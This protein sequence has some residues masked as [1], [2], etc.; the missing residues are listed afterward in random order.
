MKNFLPHSTVEHR[1]EGAEKRILT[2]KYGLK[3]NEVTGDWRKLHNEGL[4]KY[5]FPQNI[6]WLVES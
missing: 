2:R 5:D 1:L 6:I 4:L 3:R